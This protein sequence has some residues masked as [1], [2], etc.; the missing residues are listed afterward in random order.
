MALK[1]GI[2][3][4]IGSGKS[5]ICQVFKLLGAP[6]FEADV[7]AKKLVNSHDQIKT[8]LIDWYGPDIYSPN[9]TIDR[10]K[11]AGI[12]F[13]DSTEM[14]KVN[15]LIHPVVRQE[16]MI[17]ANQ[18]NSPYVIH[19][20]AILFESGFYK[21]MEY[22]LLV[23]APE[24][25]RIERVMKRDG[26]TI[27]AVKERMSKQWSDEQKRKLASREIKNDNKTL[28]IPQLIEIDKQL[29]EYGKIW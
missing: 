23:T 21:M 10:K 27:E 2:T 13:T 12:I 7:W 24:N 4:G 6:V 18:Q 14:K 20:A 17:W 5:V 25:I 8:G 16:F 28:L 3:G 15:D 11:L 22:T 19:E 26:S 9:G 1:I 29:K